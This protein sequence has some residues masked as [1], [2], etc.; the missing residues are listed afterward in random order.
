MW[1][2]YADK[3]RGIV[4]EFDV[5]SPIFTGGKGLRPVKYVHNRP[6]WDI[7]AVLGSLSE[8][9]Q[10]DPIILHKNEEWSYEKELRHLYM[11][12]GL[13]RRSLENG[14]IGYFRAVPADSIVSVRLGMFCE[15]SI[16]R[17]VVGLCRR[18]AKVTL[19]QAVPSDTEFAMRT[20]DLIPV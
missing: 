6:R 7:A 8:K 16:I 2:H 19:K 18:M 9:A 17:E 13:K 20:K 4:I 12:E 14:R 15:R 5:R 3:H 10:I 11:L 1:S